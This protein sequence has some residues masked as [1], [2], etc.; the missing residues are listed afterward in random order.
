ML[1]SASRSAHLRCARCPPLQLDGAAHRIDD[2]G[3]LDEQPVPGRLDD[4]AAVLLD[5]RVAQLAA[6]RF[7]RGERAFLVRTHQPRISGNIGG[8]DRGEWRSLSIQPPILPSQWR[9]GCSASTAST[10][11]DTQ[12]KLAARPSREARSLP[13]AWETF[14]SDAADRVTR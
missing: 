9:N 7:Q 5:L 12:A 1:R 11:Y 2:A 3:E 13:R 14:S 4:A 8:Q 10:V 6:D